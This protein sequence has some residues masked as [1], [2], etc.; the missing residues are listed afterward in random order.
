[1][2]SFNALSTAVVARKVSPLREAPP[3][4]VMSCALVT[5]T[6][7][8]RALDIVKEVTEEA[9]MPSAKMASRAANSPG[10]PAMVYGHSAPRGEGRSP[11][12]HQGSPC[13]Q[14]RGTCWVRALSTHPMIGKEHQSVTPSC[15]TTGLLTLRKVTVWHQLVVPLALVSDLLPPSP[16]P[17]IV[18]GQWVGVRYGKVLI[19]NPTYKEKGHAESVS[20]NPTARVRRRCPPPNIHGPPGTMEFSDDDVEE[21]K[22]ELSNELVVVLKQKITALEEQ[23]A[24]LHLVVYDQ[25]DDFCV[26]RKTTTRK[27]KRFAKVLGNPSLY[28]APSP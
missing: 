23:V 4:K 27:L 15:L 20:S 22:A 28:D 11:P 17:Y 21:E 2:D 7:Q 12:V 18:S 5:S 8:D 13:A 3:A 14:G 16:L 26:L 25:K 1:M 6:D 24:K 10:R 9:G 19:P